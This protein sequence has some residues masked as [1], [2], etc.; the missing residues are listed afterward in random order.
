M[1]ISALWCF[2]VYARLI[3]IGFELLDRIYQEYLL[4]G[5]SFHLWLYIDTRTQIA[6]QEYVT[7]R[8]DVKQIIITELSYR[9]DRESLL[10]S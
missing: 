8:K 9:A 6:N 1:S 10:A 3:S 4:V 7:I 5:Q 2:L